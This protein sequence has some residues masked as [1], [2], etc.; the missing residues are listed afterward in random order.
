LRR[1]TPKLV[2]VSVSD[3]GVGIA[4]EK[5]DRVFNAFFT[6]SP[7]GCGTGLAISRTISEPH[8]DESL[9]ILS[10]GQAIGRG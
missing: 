3:T 9:L 7:M 4:V 10:K 2:L 5:M 1:N 6:T 8:G